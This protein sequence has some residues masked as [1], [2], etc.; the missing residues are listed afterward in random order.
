MLRIQRALLAELL[1]IWTQFGKPSGLFIDNED[2]IYVS[3]GL[4][5]VERPG[6]RDN[7][8]W[9]RGIRIGSAATGWVSEFILDSA[10][11]QGSGIEFLA[12]DHNG[13]IY[14]GEV[15]K[16]RLAVYRLSR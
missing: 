1:F 6:W 9:E 14:A 8:G 13:T 4:S 15:G 11:P 16:Q 2:R 5:G 10:V 3:D 12:A 7:F